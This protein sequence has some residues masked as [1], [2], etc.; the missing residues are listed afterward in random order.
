MS[1]GGGGEKDLGTPK[2]GGAKFMHMNQ[3]L[4]PMTREDMFDFLYHYDENLTKEEQNLV[5]KSSAMAIGGAFVAGFIGKKLANRMS[6]E[7]LVKRK[8]MPFPRFPWVAR[9]ATSLSFASVPFILV[10][11]WSLEQVL[12]MNDQESMFALNVKRYMIQQRSQMM[13][14]RG[15]TREVTEQEQAA[16]A[17]QATT[18]R[19]GKQVSGARTA[20]MDVNAALGGQMLTPV[21]QTGYKD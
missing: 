2:Q 9:W 5:I 4:R 21:A 8:V 7:Q 15:A 20:K 13:F 17:A 10:Q 6:F 16:F 18:I 19:A 1:V 14:S 11:E 3:N 12:E